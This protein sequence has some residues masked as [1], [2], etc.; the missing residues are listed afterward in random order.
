L[1]HALI[2]SAPGLQLKRDNAEK[3]W[4][5]VKSAEKHTSGAKQAA[6]KAGKQVPQGLKPD[7]FSIIYGTT[8]VVP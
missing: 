5:R 7:V 1:Y 2:G 3:P 8:K 4:I 6:E